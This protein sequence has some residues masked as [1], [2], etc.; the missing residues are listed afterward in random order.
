MI[1]TLTKHGN[2]YALVIEKPILDLLNIRPGTP[3]SITTDGRAL[4]VS[5]EDIVER[6][7]VSGE[8]EQSLEKVNHRFA[9]VLKRL[10]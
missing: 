3:L 8:F 9:G 2:S 10:A 1:K 5:P 4:I 6:S 7:G